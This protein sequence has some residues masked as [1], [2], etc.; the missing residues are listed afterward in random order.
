MTKKSRCWPDHLDY[1]VCMFG[2]DFDRRVQS[3]GGGNKRPGCQQYVVLNLSAS[4]GGWIA[5]SLGKA[6]AA[7]GVVLQGGGE[8]EK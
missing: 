8:V 6:P 1:P 3:M 2:M 4:P 5:R 7:G